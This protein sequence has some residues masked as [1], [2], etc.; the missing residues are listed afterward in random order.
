LPYL[1]NSSLT[2][3]PPVGGSVG[4]GSGLLFIW[5]KRTRDPGDTVLKY[6]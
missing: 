3:L 4:D 1:R 2:R 5:R 6:A